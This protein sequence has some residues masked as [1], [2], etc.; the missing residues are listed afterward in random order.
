MVSPPPLFDLNLPC[1]FSCCSCWILASTCC[2]MDLDCFRD[3]IEGSIKSTSSLLSSSSGCWLATLLAGE[4]LALDI[5][6]CLLT[7]S[8]TA[9]MRPVKLLSSCNISLFVSWVSLS[10]VSLISEFTRRHLEFMG[11]WWTPLHL[12]QLNVFGILKLYKI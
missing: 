8:S 10:L 11:R 6:S 1:S 3:C 7:F 4:Y 9:A 12:L 5:G 2:C